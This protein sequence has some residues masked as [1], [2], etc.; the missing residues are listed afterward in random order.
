[1]QSVVTPHLLIT[2]DDRDFRETLADAFM[3]RGLRASV[4]ADGWDTLRQVEMHE[5]HLLLVDFQMPGLS[6][7]ETIRRV[8]QT[9]T[10]LPCILVSGAVDHLVL[11]KARDC[12]IYSVLSKPIS[13]RQTSAIVMRALRDVYAWGTD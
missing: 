5:F 11:E 1:M 4:S 9:K 13:F 6:G 7:L 10:R 12:L 2:D 8:Q 3:A